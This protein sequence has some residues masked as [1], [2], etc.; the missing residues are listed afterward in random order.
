VPEHERRDATS[1]ATT[2]STGA[3][4]VAALK[5]KFQKHNTAA[6]EAAK[7]AA[8]FIQGAITEP[9]ETKSKKSKKVKSEN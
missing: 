3:I 2:Q 7:D 5:S 8:S 6:A 9:A 4:D 1:A